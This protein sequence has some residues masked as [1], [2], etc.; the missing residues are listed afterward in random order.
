M[1]WGALQLSMIKSAWFLKN[2]EGHEMGSFTVK[3]DQDVDLS[4]LDQAVTAS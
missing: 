4:Y 1:R 3:Y 2:F